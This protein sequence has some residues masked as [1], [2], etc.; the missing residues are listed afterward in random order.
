LWREPVALTENWGVK[1]GDLELTPGH[2]ST[3]TDDHRSPGLANAL[4]K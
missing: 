2:D 1:I 3:G 4:V